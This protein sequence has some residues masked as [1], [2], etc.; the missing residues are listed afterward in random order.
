M[1]R[2]QK[3]SSSS[4]VVTQIAEASPSTVT[5]FIM[6]AVFFL[7]AMLLA[8]ISGIFGW[9][10]LIGGIIV[11]AIFG[12][13]NI[14]LILFGGLMVF[15]AERVASKSWSKALFAWLLFFLFDVLPLGWAIPIILIVIKV[16]E[17]K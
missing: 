7:S 9:I 17:N 8:L 10:P 13:S 11:G 6:L 1:A 15:I 14:G 5:L 16:L 4:G 12:L 2:K 3:R